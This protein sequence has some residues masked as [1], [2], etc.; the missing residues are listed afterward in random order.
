MTIKI[1]KIISG[2]HECGSFTYIPMF[3]VATCCQR[4]GK[5]FDPKQGI[6]DWCSLEDYPYLNKEAKP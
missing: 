1:L 5:T 3:M 2:C 6:P 4:P